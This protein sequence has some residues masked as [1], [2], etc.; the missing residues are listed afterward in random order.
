MQAMSVDGRMLLIRTFQKLV[1]DMW[2]VL[3]WLWIWSNGGHLS[4]HLL[5]PQ[6]RQPHGLLSLMVEK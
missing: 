5:V 4:A 6:E 2:A 3:N 1:V